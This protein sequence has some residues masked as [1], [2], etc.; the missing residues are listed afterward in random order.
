MVEE[1][2]SSVWGKD[3]GHFILFFCLRCLTCLLSAREENSTEQ[4]RREEKRRDEKEEKRRKR[5]EE[6]RREQKRIE[7]L[8]SR[9]AILRLLF[10]SFQSLRSEITLLP[11]KKKRN[12]STGGRSEE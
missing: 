9:T 4:R 11:K 8:T 5:R 2:R 1:I 10:I 3:N 12:K 6:T 7:Q